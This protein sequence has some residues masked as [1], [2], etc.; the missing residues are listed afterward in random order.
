[1]KGYSKNTIKNYTSEFSVLLRMLGE[2]KNIDDLTREEI[3]SYLLWLIKKKGYG[4]SHVNTA[5]NAIKFYFEEVK[6]GAPGI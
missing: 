3:K 4:E 2:R 6:N 1:L 5:V